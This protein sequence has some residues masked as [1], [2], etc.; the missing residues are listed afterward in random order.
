MTPYV[1]KLQAYVDWDGDGFINK[2]VPIGT[3]VNLVPHAAFPRATAFRHQTTGSFT[4]R[5]LA[6]DRYGLVA[7]E[8]VLAASERALFGAEYAERFAPSTAHS[9]LDT[10]SQSNLLFTDVTDKA[11]YAVSEDG[12]LKWRG[13]ADYGSTYYELST[14]CYVFGKDDLNSGQIPVVSGQTYTLMFYAIYTNPVNR[15]L[16]NFLGANNTVRQ[17]SSIVN[18]SNGWLAITF[19]ASVTEN[20]KLQ[21]VPIDGVN[22]IAIDY[23]TNL[24]WMSGS[25]SAP[26]TDGYNVWDGAPVIYKSPVVLES[27]NNY[28]VSFVLQSDV[29]ATVTVKLYL[30]NYG[31]IGSSVLYN[32]SHALVAGE[33]LRLH[34]ST[35]VLSDDVV[36]VGQIVNQAT[37]ITL[38]M[39]GYQII[40][41]VG[42][43]PFSVGETAGYDN[44]TTDTLS[45]SW[46]LGRRKFDE[47]IAYEGTA[48]ITLY[49]HDR[50]YSPKNTE[51]PL[52]G[53]LGRKN[54]LAYI[55]IEHPTT[56]EKHRLFT[57][58]TELIDVVVGSRSNQQARLT[59]RQGMFRLR[60]GDFSPIVLEETTINDVLPTL[61]EMAGWR[62][63]SHPAQAILDYDNRVGYSSFLPTEDNIYERQQD[64]INTY[65]LI[66]QGWDDDTKISEALEDLLEAEGASFWLGREGKLNFV[67][68]TFYL[69]RPETIDYSLVL[70]T[71]VQAGT[72]E[73]GRDMASV[74]SVYSKPKDTAKNQVI[75]STKPAVQVNSGETVRIQMEFSFEGGEPRTITD[76]SNDIDLVAYLQTKDRNTEPT[77]VGSNFLENLIAHIENDYAGRYTLVL[78]NR[79]KRGLWVTA[80][81]RGDYVVGGEGVTYEFS[82]TDAMLAANGINRRKL[83]SFLITTEEEAEGLAD[84][85]FL[86]DGVP[87]G[88][89]TSFTLIGNTEAAAQS[90]ILM[91]T[92]DRLYI[93]EYQ[94]GEAD[95]PHVILGEEG[96]FSGNVLT[97][98]YNIGRMDSTIYALAGDDISP[99]FIDV[100]EGERFMLGTGDISYVYRKELD[101]VIPLLTYYQTTKATYLAGCE[102]KQSLVQALHNTF[103]ARD[104]GYGRFDK[105]SA[106]YGSSELSAGMLAKTG[107]YYNFRGFLGLNVTSTQNFTLYYPWVRAGAI[108]YVPILRENNNPAVW[109]VPWVTGLWNEV[110]GM[111]QAKTRS[112]F[113]T[114]PS[115]PVGTFITKGDA[116]WTA[117]G[118]LEYYPKLPLTYLEASTPYTLVVSLRSSQN[119]TEMSMTARVVKVDPPP[120]TT[121][122]ET[123]LAS[124]SFEPEF[125]G[126]GIHTVSFT[127]PAGSNA[128]RIELD[129]DTLTSY[130]RS[131]ELLE[132]G[133]I[134]GSVA[135]TVVGT[136]KSNNSDIIRLAV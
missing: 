132:F 107:Q 109:A 134:K 101:D 100:I 111:F 99:E 86:R 96:S 122:G 45:L 36:V 66:G 77:E 46:D 78:E 133:L 20:L 15:L 29:S 87:D 52:Y 8:V 7:R 123:T 41:A 30:Q 11:R 104:D 17:S 56:L 54:L 33:D 93:D 92:G 48:E 116:I 136:L 58:W 67:N 59:L 120:Y 124:V 60:E 108:D 129:F 25:V 28:T 95:K 26:P 44:I 18:F 6:N 72:Y 3:P 5:F 19:A 53:I 85:V 61:I 57:G 24:M 105:S 126:V 65:D 127:S 103:P 16:I 106:F 13:H 81:V 90:L 118:Q 80:E 75:W 64:S 88:E 62:Y 79:N 22:T 128:V 117:M 27:G 55:E 2:G 12:I 14:T 23:Y 21:L 115:V 42:E 70:D 43:Y 98:K 89:F 4:N 76:V 69:H 91:Q 74:V 131:V 47:P 114:Y 102:A 9:N 82:D 40:N 73:F 49:N 38:M 113:L 39:R 130:P 125:T 51:S 35:G 94:T 1:P 71:T 84:A 121:T 50:I 37:P 32:S 10:T 34:I 68:R 31:E 119:Y 135:P 110:N 97:I 63:T 83:T 112:G